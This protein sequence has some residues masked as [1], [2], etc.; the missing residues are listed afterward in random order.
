MIFLTDRFKAELHRVKVKDDFCDY[1]KL[2]VVH[3]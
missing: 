3:R 1:Y 2:V